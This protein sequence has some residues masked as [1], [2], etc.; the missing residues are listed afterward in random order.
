MSENARE[1]DW[2]ENW[3]AVHFVRDLDR[4]KPTRFVLLGQP[5]AIWWQEKTQQWI[6]FRDRCTHRLAALSEGRITEDGCLECPY[7]GWAFNETGACDRIP[8]Q[9]AKGTAHKNPRAAVQTYPVQVVQDIL[10]VYPGNPENAA[11]QTVPTIPSLDENREQWTMVDV[12]RD[13]PYDVITLLENVLDSSH[14]SFTHHPRVGN[15]ANAK[16]FLLEVSA[17][18]RSGF[19]GFWEEGPRR[20]KL[21][22]QKTTFKAP[23][24][25]WHNI[26]DS[27]F[28]QVMTVVYAT[29]MEKGKCRALVRLPF[30]FKSVLPRLVFKITPRWYSHLAQMSILEDDQIFLHLQE[31][32][33][34]RADESYARAFYLP[35]HS[36]RFVAAYRQWV[37]TYGEPFPHL[38][39]APAETNRDILLERYQSHTQNCR[40]C[41]AALKQIQIVRNILAIALLCFWVALPLGIAEGMPSGGMFAI[42]AFIPLLAGLWWKLGQLE[43][44]F[45][46][47]EYPPT[48]NA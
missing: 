16:E 35:T 24:L 31:R 18:E 10:F 22:P 4:A 33:L 38:P 17:V 12:F 27:P 9:E 7:H 44:R 42:A 45:S 11:T 39:F 37:A 29:P 36:D 6:A 19:T 28:G 48:R 46:V 8:F 3:Y 21:G 26:A 40:S 1:F 2:L 43:R 14:V 41:Q 34:A 20:G 5:L 15:R 32:E 23:N 25:M 30:R 13:I 47:G